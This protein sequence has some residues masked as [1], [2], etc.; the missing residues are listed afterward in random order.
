MTL[1]SFIPALIGHQDQ[2]GIA[3]CWNSTIFVYVFTPKWRSFL[4]RSV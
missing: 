4:F 1:N 3:V 2:I